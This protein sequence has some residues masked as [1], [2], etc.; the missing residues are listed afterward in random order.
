MRLVAQ[1]SWNPGLF[2]GPQ[3]YIVIKN[4][5]VMSFPNKIPYILKVLFGLNKTPGVDNKRG[6]KINVLVG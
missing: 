4:Q 6:Q 1:K 5:L 3:P 2:K